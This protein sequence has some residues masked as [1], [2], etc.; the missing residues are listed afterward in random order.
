MKKQYVYGGII[1]A[2]LLVAACSRTPADKKQSREELLNGIAGSLYQEKPEQQLDMYT[3][4]AQME[5]KVDYGLPMDIV[6]LDNQVRLYEPIEPYE[7]NI[8]FSPVHV[9]RGGR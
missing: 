6:P 2:Q 1:F 8:N 5:G 4:K 3:V 9:V 7:A